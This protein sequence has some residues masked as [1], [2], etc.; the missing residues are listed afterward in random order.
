MIQEPVLRPV[1]FEKPTSGD[2]EVDRAINRAVEAA[3]LRVSPILRDLIREE[4]KRVLE[5]AK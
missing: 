5:V 1:Q 4:L 3:L 2:V